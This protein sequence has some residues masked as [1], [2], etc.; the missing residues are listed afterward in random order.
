[1]PHEIQVDDPLEFLGLRILEAGDQE[2]GGKMHPSIE[3]TILLHGAVRHHLYLI[4]FRDVGDDGRRFPAII[5]DLLDQRGEPL[6]APSA[7]NYLSPPFG[8]P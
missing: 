1:M 7:N 3:A 2:D 4:K 8:E 5:L 6:L